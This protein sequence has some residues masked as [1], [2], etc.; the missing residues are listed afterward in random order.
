M[1]TTHSIRREI[2]QLESISKRMDNLMSSVDSALAR[3][4]S[5]SSGI[6]PPDLEVKIREELREMRDT[7]R[8]QHS[9]IIIRGL[10]GNEISAVWEVVV[11]ELKC[12]DQD[13]GIYRATVLNDD[14]RR[15]LLSQCY[16][17]KQSDTYKH[18][19]IHR[20]LTYKQRQELFQRR[21]AARQS[22]QGET[23]Q[24]DNNT[25]NNSSNITR[26]RT[27]VPGDP[28]PQ[29][30]ALFFNCFIS[31]GLTQWVV[32]PTYYLSGNIL[33]LILTTSEDN[34]GEVKVFP[35]FPNCDHCPV[36]CTYVCQYDPPLDH[37]YSRSWHKGDYNSINNYL[38]NVDW[39]FE[40]AHFDVNSMYTRFLNIL[41]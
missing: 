40:F 22:S 20:D 17:L 7:E 25:N 13:K 8:R 23:P 6:N 37:T 26:P 35:P 5:G 15:T 36:Y 19:F 12:V 10:P 28:T 1:S 16:K 3:I 33:D 38:S 30:S 18:V 9:I 39:D 31:L 32:E 27:N 4:N 14:D 24:V 41:Y 34:I 11:G 21:Q 2:T 29:E